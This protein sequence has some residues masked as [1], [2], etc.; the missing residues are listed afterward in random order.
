MPSNLK[1]S[2]IENVTAIIANDANIKNA[3]ISSI[4]TTNINASS[5]ITTT[6]QLIINQTAIKPENAAIEK[7]VS[8]YSTAGSYT[9]TKPEGCVRVKVQLV[10]G[11]GGAAGYCES[12]GGGG[13]AEEIIDVSSIS[14][15][16]VTVGGGG[17]ASGY[18]SAAG[19]GGTSSFG[20]YLSA[21]GGY[22]ANRNYSHTGGQ[23]GMGS[24]GMINMR[25]GGG[26]GH[27]NSAASGALGFGGGT[28]FGTTA[29]DDRN[30]NNKKNGNGS[31]GA[32]GPGS[33]TDTGWYGQNG[34]AGIV[35]VYEYYNN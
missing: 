9:W 28:Y 30:T 23:G 22:G 5:D 10:G 34:E 19:D 25:G 7:S 16:A 31:P 1:V 11:G 24:G 18:Y 33:R 2:Q 12:G 8:V 21:S 35:I 27:V 26:C 4:N 3:T 15:V 32:G 6:G 17:G 13:Y 14:T 29:G 20:S